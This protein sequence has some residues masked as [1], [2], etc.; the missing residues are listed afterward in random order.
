LDS[1]AFVQTL[2][3]AKQAPT[4]FEPAYA[5][6]QKLDSAGTNDQDLQDDNVAHV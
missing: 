3:V 1:Y 2:G 5:N 6:H 4:G